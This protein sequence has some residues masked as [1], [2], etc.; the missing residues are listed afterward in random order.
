MTAGR[1]ERRSIA[2]PG[3]QGFVTRTPSRPR[4]VALEPEQVVLIRAR[5][6]ALAATSPLS[7]D[8]NRFWRKHDEFRSTD[9]RIGARRFNGSVRPAAQAAGLDRA[10]GR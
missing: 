5:K 7:H 8:G 3:C 4:G 10:A 2:Q 6:S 9:A 1:A